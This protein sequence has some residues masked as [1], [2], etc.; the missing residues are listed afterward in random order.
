MTER[1]VRPGQPE[2]V[3]EVPAGAAPRGLRT[4]V[5]AIWSDYLG[6]SWPAILVIAAAI[7][8]LLRYVSPA[9]PHKLTISSGPV[10]STFE[11]DAAL[12]Q[13][14]LA[15]NGIT[16]TILNSQGSQDNLQR[17]LDPNS[18]VDIALIQ[19]G[20]VESTDTG[21]LVSL[22]SVSF[23]PLTIFYRAARPIARLSELS[24][25]RIAIGPEG[26]GTRALAQALLKAN[27]IGP[28]GPTRLLELE[29]EAA[30]A[31][32]LQH[33]I[34]ALFL[35]GDSAPPATIREM[36]H[37]EGIR[38][39]DFPQ[40]DAY[41][42]RFRYLSKLA[43][44]AGVFDLGE[45]LPLLPI[46]MLS[47]T[48][49]LV[50][51][52][53]LHPALSDLLIEAATEVHGPATLLQDA[54]Q[55]PTPAVHSF[56]ISRDATRF[57]KSGRS[58]SY[59]YL[60]FWLA[61]LLDRVVVV[62]LPVLFVLIPAL[63]YIPAIYNW[64]V[65]RRIHR[66][67]QELMALEREAIRHPS[68]ERRGEL[69]KRL[70]GIERAVISVRVPGSHAEQLYVLREHIEYVRAHLGG[71]AGVGAPASVGGTAGVGGAAGEG[72]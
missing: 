61:S 39:F 19:S 20:V 54:G 13:K 26:S 62:L 31:A 29:G 40:A 70:G 30:R 71:T 63:R 56:P 48:V 58:F 34:D 3:N 46:N 9:P 16:L 64:R 44:P 45:N 41:V 2:A 65:S 52:A 5:R 42:R 68:S 6:R 60:P 22:G 14:I 50:A 67:Y 18:H 4:V 27:G 69:L 17:L 32:L 55:F 49:E 51:H 24:G 25:Q 43:V 66:H 38:L 15:R 8:V 59:R 10:G 23:E 12:Y 37:A 35:T 53:S 33:Q 47:P 72:A 7:I 28:G 36:L 21:D 1:D 11:R 57:Y